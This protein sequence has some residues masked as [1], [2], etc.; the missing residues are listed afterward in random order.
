MLCITNNSI[1]HKSYV[2]TQLNHP[3]ALFQTSQFSM[4]HLF[5]HSLNLSFIWSIDRTLSGATTPGQSGPRLDGNEGVLHFPQSWNIIGASA[6][7]CLMSYSGRLL[8]GVFLPL[9]REA[10]GVFYSPTQFG[11][12]V[13]S[14]FAHSYIISSILISNK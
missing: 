8:W 4:S 9:F 12:F 13:L 11:C 7:G 2:Y 5:S 6:T 1:K 14:F 10:V 3:T